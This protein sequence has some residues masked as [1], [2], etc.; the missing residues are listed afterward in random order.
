MMDNDHMDPEDYYDVMA[1]VDGHA[2]SLIESLEPQAYLS[3]VTLVN[4]ASICT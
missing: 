2:N 4:D 1:D 3:Q